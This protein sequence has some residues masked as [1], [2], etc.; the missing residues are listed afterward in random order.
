[1]QKI[2]L[3]E[4]K[5]DLNSVIILEKN[6]ISEGLIGI[7]ASKIKTY[8]N[9]PSIVITQSANIFKG[10]ARSIKNFDMGK[11]IKKT[12]DLNLIENGGG[13]NLAAGFTIKKENINNFKKFIYKFSN[14]NILRI[15]SE[16]FSKISFN[17]LNN[18]FLSD[19]N[20]LEPYG[21]GNLSPLFLIEN[22]KVVKA[23][24]VKNNLISCFLKNK[25]GK[26]LPAVSFN[27]SENNISK[28]LINNKNELNL[29]VQVVSNLWNN[30]KNLQ[31]VIIDIIKTPDKG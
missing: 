28:I 26:I 25:S 31:I 19:L 23:K 2:N 5:L 8:F 4:I 9:K 24:I 10:S 27:L 11:L 30:K 29:I 21:E 1:M 6:N 3:N 7:I 13:H 16:Y 14:D 20:K 12:L 15:K 22:I 18:S 17:A